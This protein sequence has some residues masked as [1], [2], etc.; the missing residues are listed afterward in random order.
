M[1]YALDTNIIIHL[2]YGTEPVREARDNALK[3]GIKLIIPPFVNYEILRGF[4]YQSAPKRE[5]IYD[6][7][8]SIYTIGDMTTATWE[9]AASIYA[10]TRRAGYTIGDADI[11]IAAF[12]LVNDYTLVTNNT[13]DFENIDG[14]RLVDWMK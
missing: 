10:N 11:L 7:M 14:L 12:C 6:K 5:A 8:R 13:K 3:Q 9:R 1:Q 4:M 2:L